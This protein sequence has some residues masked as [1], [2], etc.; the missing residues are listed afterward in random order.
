ML[1]IDKILAGYLLQPCF[2]QSA[3]ATSTVTFQ[4]DENLT[5]ESRYRMNRV[6]SLATLQARPGREIKVEEFLK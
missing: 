2:S 3:F 1:R 6:G 5:E 4:D